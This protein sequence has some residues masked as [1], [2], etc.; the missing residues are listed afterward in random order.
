MALE[1]FLFK[2]LA[3]RI[4]L[5]FFEVEEDKHRNLIR[6]SLNMYFA[7]LSLSRQIL[8]LVAL[9][10]HTVPLIIC[11]L[12]SGKCNS[13]CLKTRFPTV[14]IYSLI[15]GILAWKIEEIFHEN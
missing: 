15:V 3:N 8:L 7:R 13:Y 10:F 2:S 5:H 1:E 6:R 12:R 4:D 9:A 11:R 14:R